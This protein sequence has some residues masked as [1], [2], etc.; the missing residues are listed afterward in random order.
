MKYKI[1]VIGCG[2]ISK[3][4]F[5]TIKNLKDQLELKAVC[6]IKEDKA[7]KY[8]KKYNVNSY[9]KYE[10][11]LKNEDLDIVSICTP[12]G[13]HPEIG[14]KAANQN[15]HVLS[16]KP[17]GVRLNEAEDF[18]NA[19]DKNGVYLF[20]VKQNRLNPG[21]AALKKAIDKNRFGQI[22]F[23]NSTIFWTRPQ[24][25]YD[26]AD[27]RGTWEFDGGCF[28]NQAS[29]YVD[30]VQWFGGAVENVVAKTATMARD[31]EAEDT[32]AA[33]LKFRNGAMGVIQTTML[34][35]PK[36][37]EGSI[38]IIGE[39]GT[40]KIGGIALNKVEKWEF[41]DYED[42]DK[43]IFQSNYNPPSV[44]G[45][46]HLQYYKNMLKVLKG[47]TK[48]STDGREGKKSLEIIL[49]IYKSSQTGQKVSI[50][51]NYPN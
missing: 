11:M 9:K 3:K 4:H 48:P 23:I 39:K 50:P 1:G 43:I 13:T 2:R 30:L 12:S 51:L 10:K 49:A 40:V 20:V 17:M 44:Y 22:Y 46:G 38:T 37:M 32:G 6:D 29:H 45:Y 35:Y 18:I 7:K 5:E 15:I 33:I 42:E 25:Y 26:L 14:I 41:E 24:E 27:W 19:C 31:I 34:T 8:S 21:I 36:N 16:E 47:K 28:M